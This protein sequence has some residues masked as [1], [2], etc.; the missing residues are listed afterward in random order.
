MKDIYIKDEG[1]EFSTV[2]FM[3]EKAKQIAEIHLDAD[4]KYG[5]K[6]DVDNLELYKIL[7]WAISHDLTVDSEVS[8]IVPSKN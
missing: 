7:G 8:V 3:S 2:I 4:G 5:N 1:E 6:L